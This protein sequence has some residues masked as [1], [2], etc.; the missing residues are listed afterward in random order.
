MTRRK[1]YELRVDG[2]LVGKFRTYKEA[3]GATVGLL[4]V[5]DRYS[6]DERIGGRL[7]NRAFGYNTGTTSTMDLAAMGVPIHPSCLSNK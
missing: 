2:G 6:V 7:F 5:H 3:L 4:A 1:P